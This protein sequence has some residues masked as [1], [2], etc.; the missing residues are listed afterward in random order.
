MTKLTT[1]LLATGLA[2][3][4]S[5]AKVFTGIITE[6]MCKLDHK[7]MNIS[8]DDKCV[9]DC[10]KGG[11]KYVLVVDGK[12]YRLSN[13]ELP[14]KFAAKKVNVTGELFPKTGVIKVEKIDLVR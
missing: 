13:Q 5:P 11:A 8:P 14:A 10:V 1:I 4:A 2:F 3:A 12:E 7:A 6:S 9:R